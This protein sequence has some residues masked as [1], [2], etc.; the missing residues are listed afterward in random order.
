MRDEPKVTIITACFNSEQIIEKTVKSVLS[1][2]YKNIEYIIIDGASEDN[3]LEVLEH[4]RKEIAH[5]ISEPDTGIGNAWNKAL[6]LSTG[7]VVG[8]LNAGDVYQNEA[9]SMVVQAFNEDSGY[10]FVFGDVD[11]CDLGGN[12]LYTWHGD[13]RFIEMIR[14][15]MFIPHPTVFVGGDIYKKFGG[16]DETFKTAIDY[17][18]MLRIIKGGARGGYIPVSLTCMM[19]GGKSDT[20]FAEGYSEVRDISVKYGYSTYKAYL[21]YFFKCTKGYTRRMIEKIGLGKLVRV[22]RWVTGSHIRY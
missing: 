6:A 7:D 22:F 16:F 13:F 11:M 15:D 18:F 19:L 14:Y 8:I 2:T 10:D 3:T 9:V 21:R 5:L 1:Q 4:Y 17:E 12:Y 20:G